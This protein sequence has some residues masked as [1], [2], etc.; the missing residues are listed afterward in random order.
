[1]PNFPSR[2]GY[3]PPQAL[4]PGPHRPSRS[5]VQAVAPIGFRKFILYILTSP[6]TGDPH[7][8]YTVG[9]AVSE[10]TFCNAILFVWLTDPMKNFRYSRDKDPFQFAEGS[11]LTRLYN[12]TRNNRLIGWNV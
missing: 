10:N 1:M 9:R 4:A 12:A 5:P 8:N 7:D 6:T 2:S 11:L 3:P